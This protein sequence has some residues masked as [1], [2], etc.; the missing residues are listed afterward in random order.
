MI[1]NFIHDYINSKYELRKCTVCPD[2]CGSV[3]WASFH[4]AKGHWVQCPVRA[5]TWVAGSVLRRGMCESNQSVGV[6]LPLFLPP[7]SSF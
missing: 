4:K 3:G 2:W 1:L 5:C 7:F 6:S